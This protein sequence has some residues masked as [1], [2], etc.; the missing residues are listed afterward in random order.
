[1]QINEGEGTKKPAT[2]KSP[3]TAKSVYVED[4]Q[5]LC[6]IVAASKQ[7][8]S[9]A[10][11]ILIVGKALHE[12]RECSVRRRV[13]GRVHVARSNRVEQLAFSRREGAPQ[14]ADAAKV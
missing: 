6:V 3:D 11:N 5:D 12:A 10:D 1:M 7:A 9:Q 2:R 4:A 13:V 8:C 14:I